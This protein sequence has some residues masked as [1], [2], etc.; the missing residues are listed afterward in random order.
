MERVQFQNATYASVLKPT[1][2][3]RWNF[4]SNAFY[5]SLFRVSVLLIKSIFRQVSKLVIC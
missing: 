5:V 2:F 4:K 3:T 1:H